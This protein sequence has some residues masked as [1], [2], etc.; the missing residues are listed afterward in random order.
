MQSGQKVGFICFI[1]NQ[2]LF[3]YCFF[4]QHILKKYFRPCDEMFSVIVVITVQCL[5]SFLIFGIQCRRKQNS[6]GVIFHIMEIT[7]TAD[8]VYLTESRT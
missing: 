5:F 3:Y 1:D 4:N 8:N 2:C 6:K 7:H